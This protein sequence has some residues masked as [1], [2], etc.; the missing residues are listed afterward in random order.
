MK[1]QAKRVNPRKKKIMEKT[2]LKKIIG[3]VRELEI[4]KSVNDSQLEFYN[5]K[6]RR[7]EHKSKQLQNEIHKLIWSEHKEGTITEKFKELDKK[8]KEYEKQTEEEYESCLT[9]MDKIENNNKVINNQIQQYLTNYVLTILVDKL[10]K[11]KTFNYKKLDKIFRAI[12]KEADKIHRFKYNSC[13]LY[14]CD[15]GYLNQLILSFRGYDD[16]TYKYDIKQYLESHLTKKTITKK[17]EIDDFK[18]FISWDIKTPEQEAQ[19]NKQLEVNLDSLKAQI[20]KLVDDYN[21]QRQK[22]TINQDNYK[23]LYIQD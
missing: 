10:N 18:E 19:E 6:K 12:E 20:K 9:A 5:K 1:R 3:A 4:K 17:F 14:I 2:T 15:D 23:Y 16:K 8:Q 22:L 13:A 11:S 21:Q 7:I